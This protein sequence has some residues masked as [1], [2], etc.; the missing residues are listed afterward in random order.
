[1]VV[2][3]NVVVDIGSGSFE[4]DAISRASRKATYVVVGNYVVVS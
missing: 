3:N 4:E 1:M 2:G